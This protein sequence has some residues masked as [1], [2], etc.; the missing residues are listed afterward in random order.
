MGA[1][2]PSIQEHYNLSYDVLSIVFLAGFGGY[3]PVLTIRI[4]LTKIPDT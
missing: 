1:N 3:V 2:L 4:Y